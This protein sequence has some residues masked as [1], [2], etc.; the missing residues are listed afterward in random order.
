MNK[1][2]TALIIFLS[3]SFIGCDQA[4]TME[5]VESWDPNSL[6]TRNN[7]TDNEL[8]SSLTAYTRKSGST[9]ICGSWNKFTEA[10]RFVD[11]IEVTY[12]STEQALSFFDDGTYKLIETVQRPLSNGYDVSETTT[13]GTYTLDIKEDGSF[14]VTMISPTMTKKYRYNV[15]AS[16][17][18][19]ILLSDLEYG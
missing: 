10:T 5:D 8:A 4:T 13:T 12:H 16:F 6:L 1:I 9:G 19:L 15:S 14:I 18:M 2:V 7:S 3:L 11:G 17:V